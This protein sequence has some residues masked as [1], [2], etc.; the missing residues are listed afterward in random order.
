M[1]MGGNGFELVNQR[2]KH[3]PLIDEHPGHD[4]ACHTKHPFSNS[5]FVS[6]VGLRNEH[7]HHVVHLMCPLLMV[8]H[9][10]LGGKQ[11]RDVKLS[12]PPPMRSIG[13]SSQVFVVI[14]AINDTEEH[15][16]WP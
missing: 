1:T 9:N 10:T 13:S 6:F 5:H 16:L 7:L 12:Q 14:V 11:L 3:S 15:F 4:V 2:T 8:G